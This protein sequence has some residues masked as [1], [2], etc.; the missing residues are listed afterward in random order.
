[1]IVGRKMERSTYGKTAIYKYNEGI[2]LIEI[3]CNRWQECH[4]IQ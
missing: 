3:N 1:M 4:R 2:T